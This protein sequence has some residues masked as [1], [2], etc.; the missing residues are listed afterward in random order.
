LTV[1]SAIGNSTTAKVIFTPAAGIVNPPAGKVSVVVSSSADTASVTSPTV[2]INANNGTSVSGLSVS[3]DNSSVRANATYTLTFNTSATGSLNVGDCIYVA[4][5]SLPSPGSVTVNGVSALASASSPSNI[6]A[7]TVPMYVAA[8]SPVSVV[9]P[10]GVAPENASTVGTY[11][12]QVS[13]SQD[14]TPVTA[15]YTLT[16]GKASNLTISGPTTAFTGVPVNFTITAKDASGNVVT[17]FADQVVVTSTDASAVLPSSITFSNGVATIPVTF[18]TAGVQSVTVMDSANNALSAVSTPVTVTLDKVTGYTVT[19]PASASAGAAVQ[20]TVNAKDS[21]GNTVTTYNGTAAV[22]STDAAAI[23][24]A[25]ITF[26]KGIATITVTFNSVGSQTVTLTD[27]SDNTIT[28]KATVNVNRSGYTVLGADGGIFN[29]GDS[30]FSGSVPGLG[31]GVPVKAVGMAQAGNG[32][33]WVLGSDG[34][35]FTFG[36]GLGFYGSLPGIGVS[37]VNPIQMVATPDA[38]GYWI[39][40]DSGK[41]Y[42]FGDAGSYGD[43]SGKLN[44]GAKAVGMTCTADGKGYYIA[45]SDGSVYAFGDAVAA[46]NP[47]L[48]SGTTATSIAC[49]GSGYLVLGSDGEVY[50]EGGA[51]YY[52]DPVNTNGLTINGHAVQIVPTID[53]QGYYILGSDGGIFTYGDATFQGSLPGLGINN[54][55][56]ALGVT[57]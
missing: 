57:P 5:N 23:L 27:S 42:N 43:A 17:N 7:I 30:Q 21:A 35:V 41:V 28:G 18:A 39:L 12:L 24:P 46:A 1:P 44:S 38:R 13:T 40:T 49:E 10:S 2:T 36:S 6:L 47:T 16:S 25:T 14:P 54:T 53:G 50:A 37:G 55:S 32:K 33:Y 48:K 45:A 11:A 15:D 52:G 9:I 19:G 31:L 56:I 3:L 20:F 4:F 26:N 22:T 8:S 51:T 34:G 29:F